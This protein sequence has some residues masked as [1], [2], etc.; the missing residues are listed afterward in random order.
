M[1]LYQELAEVENKQVETVG[2][3]I[4]F[5]KRQGICRYRHK[6]KRKRK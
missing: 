2:V 6:E 1:E 5:R 4:A 3:E